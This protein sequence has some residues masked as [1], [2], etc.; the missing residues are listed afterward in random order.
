L[1]PWCSII[2]PTL[3]EEERLAVCLDALA[4]DLPADLIEVI[5]ADGGSRDKTLEVAKAW[6]AITVLC[7]CGRARQMN[8]GAR[9][10]RGHFLWFLHADT[11]PPP[12]WLAQLRVGASSGLPACFSLRFDQGEKSWWLRFFAWG[13]RQKVNAFRFG[14]Q[15]LFVAASEFRVMG[16]YREDHLLMEGHEMILRLSRALGDILLLPASVTTS[17]RRYL[18]Y[19]VVRTQLVFLLI[20]CLYYLGVAQPR[21]RRLYE[22][23]FPNGT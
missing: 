22:W 21:L 10:A 23:A 14:D 8:A 17:A 5:V 6:G 16:G 13:S 3:N 7:T 19:G 20:F 18:R 2:I 9:M 1:S 12:H 15:S 11:L 4:R